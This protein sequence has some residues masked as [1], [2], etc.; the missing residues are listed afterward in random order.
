MP[1]FEYW[2]LH[3]QNSQ[4]IAFCHITMWD[5]SVGNKTLSFLK[6][7]SVLIW[8][9]ILHEGHRWWL[10]CQN[11]TLHQ[12]Q[13]LVNFRLQALC[14]HFHHSTNQE[15]PEICILEYQLKY[16]ISH[17]LI[18]RLSIQTHFGWQTSLKINAESRDTDWRMHFS[19]Q[20]NVNENESRLLFSDKS[21]SLVKRNCFYQRFCISVSTYWSVCIVR[22]LT[23]FSVVGWPCVA[24]HNT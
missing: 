17:W 12:M 3:I 10:K 5:V 6:P 7:S 13:I 21:F 19:S 14:Y 4:N 9:F 22:V 1:F 16:E 18:T 20:K 23:L 15:C 24:N 11:L 2:N 8:T